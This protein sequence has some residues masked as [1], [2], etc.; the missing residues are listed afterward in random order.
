MAALWRND[1]V[2]AAPPVWSCGGA[3]VTCEGLTTPYC[4]APGS[5][6]RIRERAK[7]A[8]REQ[9]LAL[10]PRLVLG[11]PAAQIHALIHY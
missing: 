8:P 7:L 10:A 6:W 3:V 1:G 2:P 9:S 5:L 11:P 4:M